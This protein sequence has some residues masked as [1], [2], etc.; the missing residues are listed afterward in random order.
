MRNSVLTGNSVGL[1]GSPFTNDGA[2]SVIADRTS[3][4][5]NDIGLDNRGGESVIILGRSTVISNGQ[6][7]FGNAHAILSY[8]NNHLTGNGTEGGPL[9]VFATKMP[10]NGLLSLK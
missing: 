2:V 9:P 5:L 3:I 4:T 7:T 10:P 1:G 6:F 8:Q